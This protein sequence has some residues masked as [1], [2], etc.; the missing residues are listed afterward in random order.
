MNSYCS[1][2]KY[3]WVTRY[4]IYWKLSKKLKPLKCVEKK[5]SLKFFTDISS[6][7]KKTMFKIVPLELKLPPNGK[8]VIS[9]T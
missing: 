8:S 5:S 4:E 1:V 2:E 9:V 6:D 3:I 7:I